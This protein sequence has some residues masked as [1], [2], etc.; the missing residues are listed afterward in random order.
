MQYQLTDATLVANNETVAV[1]ADSISFT[2]GLGERTVRGASV[3]GGRVEQVSGDNLE[4][5]ISSLKFQLP[6]TPDNV[7]LARSWKVNNPLNV[8][9]VAG[10]AG[11]KDMTRTFT[12][13]SVVNDYEVEVGSEGN[14]S[15]EVKS[16]AAI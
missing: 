11:G 10:S 12:Q 6:S 3:G 5:K 8:F 15:I 16:N 7:A 13:A 14:I 1:V 2:E 4:T 9:H